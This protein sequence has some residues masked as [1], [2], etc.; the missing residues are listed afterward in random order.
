MEKTRKL[1]P[2]L[3]LVAALVF[4]FSPAHA[5]SPLQVGVR[6]VKATKGPEGVDPR[7]K[8]V[9][10]DLK[11]VLNYSSFTLLNQASLNLAA[12]STGKVALPGGR[13]L[14]LTSLG[15]SG[16]RARLQVRLVERGKETFSTVLAV[17]NRGSAVIGGPAF[18]DGVLLFS[19][20]ARF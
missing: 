8:D 2:A 20:A 16:S 12:N 19:I 18:E 3:C 13:S 10:Q 15:L 5:Q 4:V 14:E 17:V 6:V 7:L 9:A 1:I 11:S